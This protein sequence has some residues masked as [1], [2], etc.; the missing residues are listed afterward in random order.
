M[1]A[2]G[3]PMKPLFLFLALTLWPMTQ[4]RADIAASSASACQKLDDS[5]IKSRGGY[6]GRMEMP[7]DQ[8]VALYNAQGRAFNDCTRKLIESNNAEMDRIRDDGNAAIRGIADTANR[9]TADIAEKIEAAIA[10]RTAVET[11]TD[12]SGWQFPDADCVA[13]DKALLNRVHGKKGTSAG[14]A[15]TAQYDAQ[16]QAHETCVKSYIDQA[17]AEMRLITENANARIKQVADQANGQIAE[18]HNLVKAAIQDANNASTAEVQAV[19]STPLELT[20]GNTFIGGVENVTVQG[21][22]PE[23]LAD[24]PKGDGDPHTIVCRKPQQLPQSRLMGPEIC[25]RN[26][27]W[28]SLYKAGK[29]LSSDGQT[30]IPSERSRTTDHAAMACVKVKVP[31]GPTD[32]SGYFTNEICN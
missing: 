11:Q 23:Q 32:Y 31:L 14:I 16:Q 12:P 5:L 8:K 2:P 24:T 19:R 29:D 26:R 10:G 21:Q 25:K 22:A 4:A 30:I 18:R 3:D 27:V 28:A 15:R 20:P 1:R 9:Q 6:A 7:D 17:A 13:P